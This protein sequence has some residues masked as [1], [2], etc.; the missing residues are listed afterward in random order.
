MGHTTPKSVLGHTG[1]PGGLLC[2]HTEGPTP[3]QPWL[4]PGPSVVGLDQR[5]SMRTLVAWAVERLWDIQGWPC[6][7]CWKPGRAVEWTV[8]LLRG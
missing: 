3:A 1:G 2:S 6:G 4:C 7:R 5:G 8:P